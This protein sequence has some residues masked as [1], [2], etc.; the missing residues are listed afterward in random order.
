MINCRIL[1]QVLALN[2]EKNFARAAKK[3]HLSQPTLTRNIQALEEKMGHKLF[4]RSPR[5][6]Q[7]T[8]F[9]E[10]VVRHAEKIVNAA[11][12]LENEI[13]QFLN[14]QSGYLKIGV[15]PFLA[16]TSFSE[17][18][19]LFNEKYPQIHIKSAVDHWENLHSQLRNEKIEFFVAETSGLENSDNLEII[20]FQAHPG[21]FYCRQDHPILEKETIRLADFMQYSMV[22]PKLPKRML[23]ML[24]IDAHFQINQKQQA[25]IECEN[26]GM[27]KKI[28]L[29]SLAIGLGTYAIVSKLLRHHGIKI[30]PFSHKALKTNHGIV[31]LKS[32][33]LSPAAQEFISILTQAEDKLCTDEAHYFSKNS[34]FVLSNS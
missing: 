9:G 15:G 33:T 5:N 20:P 24:K 27:S 21:F 25:F 12:L 26:V 1:K 8:T 29:N 28:V 19:G 17:A 6:L 7:L 14:L 32:H 22:F 31:K 16:E 3:L 13:A 4:D 2:E 30:I 34:K 23:Q 10:M 18:I 11:S